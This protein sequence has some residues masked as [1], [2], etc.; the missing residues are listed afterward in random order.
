MKI[1]FGS[2]ADYLELPQEDVP[3]DV[4]ALARDAVHGSLYEMHWRESFSAALS[5]TPV[6]ENAKKRAILRLRALPREVT[7]VPCTV[8]LT[9]PKKPSWGTYGWK[10]DPILPKEALGLGA[11]LIDTAETYGYG[12]VEKELGEIL[13]KKEPNRIAT[14]VS[15][16]HMT[17]TNVLRAAARSVYNLGEPIG[18]YQIHWPNTNVPIEDTFTALSEL[19]GDKAHYVG[20]CNHSVDQFY[21]A[22]LICPRL[23]SIQIRL[24]GLVGVLPFFHAMGIAVIAHSPLGQG[25]DISERKAILQWCED[26]HVTP[27]IGT[28]NLEHLRENMG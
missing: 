9:L 3:E 16:N 4:L 5:N 17:Y 11:S 8:P 26:N 6:M 28:N 20:V 10:Y 23:A 25:R 2:A 1:P 18:L 12:R 21:A 13:E 15:R 27:I 24:E 19:V 14:K 22:R 7:T